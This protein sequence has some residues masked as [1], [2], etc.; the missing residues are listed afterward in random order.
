MN[1][2]Y[3]MYDAPKPILAS[4]SASTSEGSIMN[5]EKRRRAAATAHTSKSV[6]LTVAD[7]YHNADAL[8]RGEPGGW[9]SMA[10]NPRGRHCIEQ[11][12]PKTYIEWRDPGDG[13]PS[14][15]QGFSLHVPQVAALPMPNKLPPITGGVPLD[16]AQPDQLAFLMAIAAKNQGARSALVKSDGS[17]EI[18]V[19]RQN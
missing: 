10:A 18:Y 14:D 7:L 19:G 6:N 3:L 8:F 15:W 12:F 2:Y 5:R 9:V 13:F 1:R 11:V 4:Y 17:I 16:E